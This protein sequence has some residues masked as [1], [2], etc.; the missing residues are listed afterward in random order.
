[1]C[2]HVSVCVCVCVRVSAL[3]VYVAG[4]GLQL[5]EGL[6]EKRGPLGLCDYVF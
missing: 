6:E 5:G 1:M 4:S 2:V 3:C